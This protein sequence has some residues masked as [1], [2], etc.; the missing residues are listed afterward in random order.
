MP[1]FAG[2]TQPTVIEGASN[3]TCGELGTYAFEFKVDDENPSG[4]Y[5]EHDG[6]VKVSAPTDFEVTI[7]PGAD[8]TMSFTANMF[9]EAVYVKGGPIG[10]NLYEYD[11]FVKSDDGLHTPGNHGISHVSFCFGTT[12]GASS[13]PT[14][15]ESEEPSQTEEPTPTPSESEE[16]SATPTPTQTP[17]EDVAG[18]NPTPTPG[19][20]TLP[21]TAVAPAGSPVAAIVLGLG[22]LAGLAT[23]GLRQPVVVRRR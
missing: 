10:G 1:A 21:D 17:R 13:T 23:I 20:G 9:V 11:P 16:P 18:G 4:T 22:L 8:N 3:K 19:G 12:P 5:D 15:S 14:P 7:T 6:D 2:S